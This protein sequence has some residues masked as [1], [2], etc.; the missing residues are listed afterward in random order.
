MPNSYDTQL[1]PKDELAFL[2]WGQQQSRDVSAEM[3]DYDLKGWWQENQDKNLSD[4]HLTDKFKKPNHP[5]FSD[6]SKYHGID[7]NFGGKWAGEEGNYSFTPGPTNL[8]HYSEEE[9]QNYFKEREPDVMLLSPERAAK[10]YGG[11]ESTQ[12]AK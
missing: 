5:T 2:A 4:G 7:N 3:E 8:K 9:L 1:S 12:E 10:F 6:E 11:K